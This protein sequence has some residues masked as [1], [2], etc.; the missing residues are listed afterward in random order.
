MAGSYSLRCQKPDGA[1]SA[2]TAAVSYIF[3]SGSGYWMLPT[4]TGPLNPVMPA[5]IRCYIKVDAFPTPAAGNTYATIM[6]FADSAVLNEEFGFIVN[7]TSAGVLS[8]RTRRNGGI[9]SGNGVTIS[10]STVYR[11]ECYRNASESTTYVYSAAGLYLGSHKSTVGG[12]FTTYPTYGV[13]QVGTEVGSSPTPPT[14]A[15]DIYID[16]VAVNDNE[17]GLESS[18]YMRPGTCPGLVTVTSA[19]TYAEWLDETSGASSYTNIDEWPS[20]HTD[21]N[22]PPAAPPNQVRDAFNL[23]NYPG[24]GAG[25]KNVTSVAMLFNFGLTGR[26]WANGPIMG[27]YDGTTA[28]TAGP[29]TEVANQNGVIFGGLGNSGAAFW[30]NAA[31][32]ATQV[33][34]ARDSGDTAMDIAMDA[35]AIEYEEG[36]AVPLGK[37]LTVD[38]TINRAGTY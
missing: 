22:Y 1:A 29:S 6:Y 37:A 10:L 17:V 28:Y 3:G 5:R 11:V 7:M 36:P 26:L 27:Y 32:N 23:T 4:Q 9:Q 18:T 31:Y 38:Q 20:S 24:V 34:Y 13:L 25:G 33:Y 35:V 19:G 2:G 30:T 8:I 14:G 16:D 15:Y 12:D 21:F